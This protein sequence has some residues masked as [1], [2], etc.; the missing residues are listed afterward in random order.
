MKTRVR[1]SRNVRF[2]AAR[3]GTWTD[4]IKFTAPNDHFHFIGKQDFH[5]K[6]GE[7]HYLQRAS[8]LVVEGDVNGDGRADFQIEVHGMTKLMVSDFNL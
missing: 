1:V 8:F 3:N 2:S 7:L 5:H 6:A 4:A